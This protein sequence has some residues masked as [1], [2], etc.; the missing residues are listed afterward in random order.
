ML[1]PLQVAGW[2]SLS[3]GSG[4]VLGCCRQSPPLLFLLKCPFPHCKAMGLGSAM[5]PRL[6][7]DVRGDADISLQGLGVG[8][9]HQ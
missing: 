4:A 1:A 9:W 3:V 8:H 6:D 7:G 2:A 5:L